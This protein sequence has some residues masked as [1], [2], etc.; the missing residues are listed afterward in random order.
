MSSLPERHF[1]A[2]S[3]AST[4]VVLQVRAGT[5]HALAWRREKDPYEGDWA[6]PGGYLEPD[7]SL[8]ASIQRHL[9]TKVD[10]REIGRA[11]V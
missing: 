10:V 8:E 5:L 6:L 7:E 2:P 9:A 1:P 4:A 3:H 11:H